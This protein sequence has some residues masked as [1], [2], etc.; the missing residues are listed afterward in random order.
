MDKKQVRLL[1]VE[2]NHNHQLD[3][4]RMLDSLPETF[5]LWL[6][7]DFAFELDAAL[8]R[9]PNSEWVIPDVF[10]PDVTGGDITQ[11]NGKMVVEA[12]IVAKKPVVMVTD[13]TQQQAFK[14]EQSQW[15]HS[16]GIELF[17]GSND[18]TADTVWR[19]PWKRALYALIFI[20]LGLEDGS[21]KFSDGRLIR[22]FVRFEQDLHERGLYFF[23]NLVDHYLSDEPLA[24]HVWPTL[25]R[26][27]DMGFPRT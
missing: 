9:L 13:Q 23:P 15:V 16:R 5:P 17:G 6:E 19:K 26:M 1:I 22:K 4:I 24:T 7:V 18:R 10:F 3:A 25:G 21:C 12:C 20:A 8:R 27:L 2:D 11:P 14:T